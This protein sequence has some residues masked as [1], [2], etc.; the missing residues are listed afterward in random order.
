MRLLLDTHILY[1]MF[2]EPAELSAAE[3]TA[4]TL[5]DCEYVA[6]SASLWELRLKWNIVDK[7]G[8][9]KG[10]VDPRDLLD[11]IRMNGLALVSVDPEHAVS[12]LSVPLGHSDP[13]DELLMVQAQQ[14]DA[15]LLTRDRRLLAHPLAYSPL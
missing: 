14:L 11:A 3:R 12:E 10:P 4:M 13:F 6:S 5:D 8:N 15:R 7:A 2:F 9:R 1:W